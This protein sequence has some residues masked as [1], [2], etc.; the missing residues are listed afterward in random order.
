LTGKS[1]SATEGDRLLI[2]VARHDWMWLA[3]LGAGS[4]A[5]AGAALLLPAALGRTVDAAVARSGSGVW[6]A[7]CALLILVFAVSEAATALAIG[8]ASANAT[9]RL[10]RYLSAHALSVGHR[11]P[12]RGGD[13]VS[14]IVGSAPAAGGGPASLVVSVA[15]AIPPVG[16]LVALGLIDPWLAVSFVLVFPALIGMLRHLARD[17]SQI[18]VDYSRVQGAITARLLDALAGART[19]AAA[20]TQGFE[21]R[22]VLAL[23]PELRGHGYAN[24]RVQA[25]AAAQSTIIAPVLQVVVVA[26]AGLEL[27]RHHLTPGG[28]TAASQYAVLATGIGATTA[29]VAR[30]GVARGGARRVAELLAVPAPEY[31]TLTNPAGTEDPPQGNTSY[32]GRHRKPRKDGIDGKHGELALQGV[33]VRRGGQSVLRDLDLVVPG[34]AAVAIVGKSGAGKS[35][36]AELAGRLADPDEGTIR[37]GGTELRRLTRAALRESVV[38]AFERPFPFG[39]TPAEAIGFGASPLAVPEITTAA[40]AAAAST[41]I[42]RLPRG[43]DT[44]LDGAPLSGG[45]MQR[46]GLARAFAR[47][48][49]ARLLVLDDATSS[50]DT[51]TEMLVS[52]TV[53]ERLR[54]RTRLIVAHRATTA[55]RADLVAWLDEGRIRALAPH[56]RLWRDPYYRSLFGVEAEIP[57]T[58][59][60]C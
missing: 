16:A 37:L 33:T 55:A 28:L 20:G 35:T 54:G 12:E 13:T 36:L 57:A 9:A 24:W 3:G 39:A 48:A 22:R 10:R 41:F 47:A 56:D 58:G 5:L 38:Y 27:S 1:H 6:V 52:R 29:M 46:L 59:E 31:G 45:E 2:S 11:L 32:R 18:A 30:L 8:I 4:L 50:L 42:E 23:L 19:I 34:G 14:R 15:A 40:E 21:R 17:S 51:V 25:R 26:V 53:T 60:R 43:Y 7:A 44:A 49:D